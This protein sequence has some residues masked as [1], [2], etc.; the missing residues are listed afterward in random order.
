[1]TT[2][3]AIF[4]WSGDK[5][6]AERKRFDSPIEAPLRRRVTGGLIIAVLL[7]GFLGFSY[8]HSAR[9]AEQDAYWVSHTYE[10]MGTI[11]RTSRHVIEAETSARAFAM[12][13]Q[14]PLLVHYQTARDSA[15]TR[16]RARCAI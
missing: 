7:T 10:V 8:W 5:E 2:V 4:G 1:V 6:M 11:Q 9:R 12:S 16:T 15:S 14:E 13:G 3:A